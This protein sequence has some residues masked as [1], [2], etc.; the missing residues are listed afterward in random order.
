MRE[1]ERERERER[2]KEREKERREKSETVSERQTTGEER[3]MYN[4]IEG[5]GVVD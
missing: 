5:E 1:I 3:D 2:E 4:A